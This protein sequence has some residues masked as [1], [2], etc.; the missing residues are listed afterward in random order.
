MKKKAENS[1]LD[2]FLK[3]KHGKFSTRHSPEEK[4]A[5]NFQEKR[6]F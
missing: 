6:Q 5:G 1:R 2:I 4:S 3:K